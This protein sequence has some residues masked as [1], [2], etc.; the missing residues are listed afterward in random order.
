M[1][2]NGL[3]RRMIPS[4]KLITLRESMGGI[5][6]KEALLSLICQVIGG[7]HTEYRYFTTKVNNHR[8]RGY[9]HL[10][11]D[12]LFGSLYTL[13]DN[14]PY[15]IRGYPKV[16]YVEASKVLN[17]EG[18][19]EGKADGT[20]LGIFNLPDDS[21][22]GKTRM[23]SR[24][25]VPGYMGQI[26]GD[27]YKDTGLLENTKSLCDLDYLPFFE[28]YGERNPCEYVQY[29]V[30]IAAMLIDVVDMRTF[31]FLSYD[32]KVDLATKFELPIPRL[33]WEGTFTIDKIS[34]LAWESE[35]RVTIDGEEGLMAKWFDPTIQDQYLGK[36]KC[37]NIRALAIK[38]GGGAIPD[39]EIKKGIRKAFDE[40][41]YLQGDVMTLTIQE[42]AEDWPDSKISISMIRIERLVQRMCSSETERIFNWLEKQI[43]GGLDV[44]MENKGV[45]MRTM[46]Q[47][48]LGIHPTEGYKIFTM[49]LKRKEE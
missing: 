14:K 30:P 47:A 39:E 19:A 29:T 37:D 41:E 1:G 49:Y 27:L 15:I 22:M 25:D 42:L 4:E 31:K 48:N 12:W 5:R 10:E 44:S 32:K 11:R 35:A 8:W 2:G 46:A 33:H 24:W 20:C 13:W 26:W 45:V 40:G 9:I 7:D 21:L 34:W 16:K 36:I 28:M 3:V 17:K 38:L 6:G 18:V 23:G 43:G